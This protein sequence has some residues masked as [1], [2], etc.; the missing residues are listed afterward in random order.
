MRSTLRTKFTLRGEFPTEDM[1]FKRAVGSGGAFVWQN[2]LLGWRTP[3][4]VERS[5]QEMNLGHKDPA[6]YKLEGNIYCEEQRQA[7]G[8]LIATVQFSVLGTDSRTL[9]ILSKPST[10]TDCTANLTH[11][12]NS[13]E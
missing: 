8:F 3:V 6:M 12:N 5:S 13:L 4:R 11:G 9:H 2:A 1:K 10:T 7:Y